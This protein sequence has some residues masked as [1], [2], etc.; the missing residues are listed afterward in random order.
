MVAKALAHVLDR[1][2]DFAPTLNSSF[3]GI[4]DTVLCISFPEELAIYTNLASEP[5]RVAPLLE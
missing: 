4:D 2:G 3:K 5:K 1:Y